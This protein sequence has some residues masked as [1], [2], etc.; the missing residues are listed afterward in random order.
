MSVT[1][2][3]EMLND[4]E[5]NY[6]YTFT[7]FTPTYNRR[8]TIDR[9]YESLKAQTFRDFE[10]LIVDDGSTDNTYDLVK[11]WQTEAEVEIRYFYQ[12]NRGK[13]VAYNKAAQEAKGRFLVNLDSD[14]ACIPEALERFHYHWNTIPKHEQDNFSGI[15]CL[16][17]DQ[18]G[19]LL[20]DLYAS[21][22]IDSNY[23]EMH[24]RH[25]ITGEKWGF[26]RTVLLQEFPFPEPSTEMPLSHIPENVVWSKLT[27]RYRARY[28]NECLRI[29]YVDSGTTQI[30]KSS[31]AAKNPVGLNLMCKSIL[32]IDIYCFRF[33]PFVFIRSAINY[34]RSCFHLKKNLNQQLTDLDSSLAKFLWTL[35]FPVGY[36]L[37]LRDKLR[38]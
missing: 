1:S 14:D 15:D 18:H 10:W 30:T 27:Q 37:W 20:G 16:C 38:T 11:Q 24:Y 4:A 21:S 25:K 7:V 28:V 22:P 2:R 36:M 3:N 29:Y 8:H 19:K 33:S 9:V 26:Q 5:R 17:Q 32:D 6:R 13:H 35:A 23:S 12:E 31:W 34:S